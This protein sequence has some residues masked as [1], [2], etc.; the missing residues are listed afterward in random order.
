MGTALITGASSGIGAAFARELAQRGMDLV[1]VARSAD[2]LQALAQDLIQQYSIQVEVV[3]QDLLVPDAVT[4]VYKAVQD[5]GWSIDLLVNNAGFGDYGLFS[6]RPRQRQLDMIGLNISALV[7][8]THQFLPNM[9]SRQSGSIL[10]V[11][12]IA[13]FQPLPYL[14]VYAATKAF[15]LSFS[16]ALWA[17]NKSNG[18]CVLAVCP[19]PTESQF[20]EVAEFPQTFSGREQKPVPAEDVVQEALTALDAKHAN[21]VTGGFG[22]QVVV[23]LSRFWPREA[24]VSSVEQFFRPPTPAQEA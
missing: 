6:D 1:L 3:V 2:K 24:L 23:N 18:V 22:N 5:L 17:E 10:N 19:G 4:T 13:A 15:V 14:S 16:E 11:A 8:L 12:S 7:D 20:F 9:V 21:I